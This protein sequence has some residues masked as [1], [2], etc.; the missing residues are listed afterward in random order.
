VVNSPPAIGDGVEVIGDA[1]KALIA[2]SEKAFLPASLAGAMGRWREPKRLPLLADLSVT[3]RSQ[4]TLLRGIAV[5]DGDPT[6]VLLADCF[7]P[8]AEVWVAPWGN[9]DSGAD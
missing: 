4:W 1:S 5:D 6:I 9:A 8:W 7:L 3:A 2:R